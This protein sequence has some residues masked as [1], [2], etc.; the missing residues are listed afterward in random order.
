ML[1]ERP[2]YE[3]VREERLFCATL[4]H[5]LMERGP[6]LATFLELV[7][8]RLPADSRLPTG[9]LEEAQVYV[10]F[11]FL[12]DYWN[13]LG[14]DNEAKRRLI[15]R[16]L[17]RVD[18]LGRYQDESFPHTISEFN[19]FFMGEPGRRIQHDIGYPGQWSVTTIFERFRKEPEEFR[20][21][22]RF[23][24][25]FNIKPDMVV[26]V[27]GSTPLCVE[28]KLESKEG[29]YPTRRRECEIFDELFGLEQGRVRQIE[30]QQFMFRVLLG[31][32]CHSM[33][34]G[35]IVGAGSEVPFLTWEEVFRKLDLSSSIGYVR[36]L[37]EGNKH[38]KA[39]P[40]D[41]DPQ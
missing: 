21:F 24:W 35:Q 19:E 18:R 10:E 37:I 5:L 25:A 6:N 23:K 15:L 11:T 36:R 30:L 4:A 16:L 9:R 7:N 34:I 33:L 31:E 22:C 40:A 32:P 38:L 27:P 3:F 26:L 41:L 1:S 20:G 12:R 39:V 13:R 14:R 17:S 28:A 8:T 2:F 29:W